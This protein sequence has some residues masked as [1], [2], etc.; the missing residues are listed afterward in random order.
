MAQVISD[1]VTSARDVLSKVRNNVTAHQ[2]LKWVNL[3]T[4]EKYRGDPNDK[5]HCKDIKWRFKNRL[6]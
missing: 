6:D 3:Y 5:N 1:A 2:L 4:S